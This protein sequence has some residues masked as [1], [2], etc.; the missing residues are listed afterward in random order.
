MLH[1]YELHNL[2]YSR[3]DYLRLSFN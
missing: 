1:S 3:G 2:S